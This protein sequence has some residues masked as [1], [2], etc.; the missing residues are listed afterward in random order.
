LPLSLVAGA[1]RRAIDDALSSA[2]L[3]ERE[4]DLLWWP[5]ADAADALS[6]RVEALV[7]ELLLDQP[8]WTAE[9][10]V[11]RVYAHLHGASTP[12]LG[13]VLVC[14]DAYS[15]QQGTAV[16]LRPEDDPERRA[17]EIESLRRNL[18]EMGERM[19]F[20]CRQG[21]EWDVRW[22]EGGDDVYAFDVTSAADLA[23]RL[24]PRRDVGEG[25]WRCLVLPGGRASLVTFKL[26]RDPRLP[27]AV[28]EDR[29]KFVKFRHLRRLLSKA[30]LDR[31]A[32]KTV[33]G[34]DPIV[35]Q[36]AAQI[37]LF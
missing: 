31:H 16:S 5:A 21:G 9:Q 34:L 1:V 24:L 11:N 26:Q 28:E 32:L 35:E 23:G 13:L 30:S 7:Y 4:G 20:T 15:V 6:D 10:I 14:V 19:G 8:S 12:D 3:D 29:W 36:A 37:P 18:V 25:A 22:L 17:K 2:R 27:Q 33:L